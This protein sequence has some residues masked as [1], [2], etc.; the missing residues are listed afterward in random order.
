MI[1]V[2]SILVPG[3]VKPVTRY[4]LCSKQLV[5]TLELK[6]YYYCGVML[7]TYSSRQLIMLGG[8]HI[9]KP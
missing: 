7:L 6:N 4:V 9:S 2:Y 1:Q 3:K 5:Y 8:S